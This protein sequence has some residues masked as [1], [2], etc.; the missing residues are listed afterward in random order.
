ME[1]EIL[2]Y[3]TW[4]DSTPERNKWVIMDVSYWDTNFVQHPTPQFI[5]MYKV[6]DYRKKRKYR[7]SLIL[8]KVKSKDLQ[9]LK[10]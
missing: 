9:L 5:I 10:N 3:T 4:V 8:E 6:G 2:P 1:E 7:Y